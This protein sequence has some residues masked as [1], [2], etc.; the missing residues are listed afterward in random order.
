MWGHVASIEREIVALSPGTLIH[1]ACSRRVNGVEVSADAL[2]AGVAFR[3]GGIRLEPYPVRPSVDGPWP[4]AGP[5]RNERMLAEGEPDRGLAFGPLW[6][7]GRAP[8]R[9]DRA[10][11]P[12]DWKHTGTG[13]M[14]AL[15]LAARL[16]VRWIAAPGAARVDLVTMP[17]PPR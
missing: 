17:G 8:S 2:A 12:R 6:N 9:L 14:V 3:R 15:M 16:P 5:R 11:D 13:G 7:L 1:G 4:A 10:P